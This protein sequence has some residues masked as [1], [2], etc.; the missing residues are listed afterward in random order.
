MS[1]KNS[2]LV[3]AAATALGYTV[4]GGAS[5][6]V[7]SLLNDR[8][9]TSFGVAEVDASGRCLVIAGL[10][11]GGVETMRPVCDTTGDVRLYASAAAAVAAARRAGV[12]DLA[13][14]VVQFVKPG[15]VGDPVK[16]LISKHKAI[17]NEDAAADKGT[18][19]I[20][21]KVGAAVALGWD[22]AVG[23]PE[24]EEYGDLIARQTSV[25]EWKTYTA[26]RLVT[27]TANL[28]TAGINPVTYAPA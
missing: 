25:A 23:T 15:T 9:V 28:V 16:A 3:A 12:G 19:T 27:L 17:K 11:S 26:A 20:T 1:L 8:D 4:A 6:V 22:V 18:A 2:A 24:A 13:I 7:E 5:P 14:P 21:A 10:T